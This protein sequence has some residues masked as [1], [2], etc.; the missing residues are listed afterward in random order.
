M[1]RPIVA[2]GK[3]PATAAI[4]LTTL[5]LLLLGSQTNAQILTT[6]HSFNTTDG[7]NPET[8]VLTEGVDGNLY[9]TTNLGGVSVKKQGGTVFQMSPAGGFAVI[10]FFQRFDGRNPVAGLVLGSDGLFYGTASSRIPYSPTGGAIFSISSSGSLTVLAK[11]GKRLAGPVAPLLQGADGNLYGTTSGGGGFASPGTVVQVNQSGQLKL[12][13]SF[14]GGADGGHPLGGLIQ[15]ADGAFY[16]TCRLGGHANQGTI[17]RVTSDDSF[18]TLYSF[19]G[20]DGASPSG[21]LTLASDGNFYGTTQG[22]GTYSVGTVFRMTPAGS[23]STLHSFNI[24]DGAA[25]YAPLLQASDGKL[26]GTTDSGGVQNMGTIFSITTDGTLASIYLFDGIHGTGP[27]GGLMQHT[28]GL[29]YGTTTFGGESNLGTVYSL[30]L[31]L[32][33]PVDLR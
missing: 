17:Y 2:S 20:S 32:A 11:L 19:S 30:D 3:N 15:G 29:L 23:V 18:T 27:E 22:G 26:Y 12:L 14:T 16:G 21:G 33:A 31:G 25:P 10:H 28:N 8:E 5:L 4:L 13:H 9:G 1:M 24:S 7:A 6:L